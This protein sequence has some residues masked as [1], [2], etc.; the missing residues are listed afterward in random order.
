MNVGR[1]ATPTT[2]KA[3]ILNKGDLKAN[4]EYSLKANR[5]AVVEIPI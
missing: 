5:R 2:D 3:E 1:K 4:L